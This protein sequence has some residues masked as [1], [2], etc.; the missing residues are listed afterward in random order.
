MAITE[1]Q[2]QERRKY[3]GSSDISAVMGLNPWR[4]ASDV[5]LEKTGRLDDAEMSPMAE[6]GTRFEAV[7]LEWC[8]EQIGAKIGP[9]QMFIHANGLL[10]CNLD[11]LIADRHQIAEAKMTGMTEDWGEPMTGEVP[12]YVACQ[13]HHQMFVLGPDWRRVWV[14]VAFVGI[15]RIEFKLYF[16]DWDD[17]VTPGVGATGERFM[18]EHVLADVP[19]ANFQPSTEVLNRVRRVPNK[20]VQLEAALLDEYLSLSAAAKSAKELADA[21][22]D[23]LKAAL[24]DAEA[25]RTPSGQTVTFFTL[26][27]KGYFVRASSFRVLRVAKK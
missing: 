17:A 8:G 20:T 27:R 10:A 26:M 11:G 19:P 12:P 23:R 18:R 13:C 22:Q 3:L 4:N 2:K 21:A 16:V 9:S 14:P 5:Y 24:G 15:R 25:G 7:T 1:Q 6:A